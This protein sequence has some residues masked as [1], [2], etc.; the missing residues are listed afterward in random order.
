MTEKRF[1]VINISENGMKG[2]FKLGN[3][4]LSVYDVARLLN[5]L[6]EENEELKS[7]NI[8]LRKDLGE[9]EKSINIQGL[10]GENE[11]LKHQNELLS[12]ELEQCKAVINNRWSEY[13]KKK[14]VEDE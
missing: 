7:E 6:W 12:D 14:G 2:L 4:N 5:E 13:L 10:I 8:D 1:K 3:D 11:Q 9:F